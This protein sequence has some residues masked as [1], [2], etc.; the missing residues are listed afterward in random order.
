MIVGQRDGAPVR[1][2]EVAT[3]EDSFESVKT[4]SSF[5]GQQLDLAGGADRQPNANTVQVVD[6]VRALMPQFREQL[7]QSVEINMVNDRSISIREAVH[8]VQL[9][10]AGHHRAGGA[11]DLPVP[12]PAWWPR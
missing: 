7:P 11:G 5:N 3:V 10:L 4:A 2:D 8:D 1:L 9:T 12:A 6:A